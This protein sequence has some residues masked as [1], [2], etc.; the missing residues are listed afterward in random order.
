MATSALITHC[1]NPLLL[2]VTSLVVMSARQ[3]TGWEEELRAVTSAFPI[4]IV[5]TNPVRHNFIFKK[6]PSGA[7]SNNCGFRHSVFNKNA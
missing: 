7:F 3:V 6:S 1:E 5:Y 4:W 2:A